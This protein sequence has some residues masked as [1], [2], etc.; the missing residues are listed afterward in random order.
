MTYLLPI[1]VYLAAAFVVTRI[2]YI[3]TYIS[4]CHTLLHEVFRVLISRGKRKKIKLLKNEFD[5][6]TAEHITLRH[7]FINYIS[8]TAVIL[9]IIG[10][11]YLVSTAN[12]KLI[13]YLLILLIAVS[14]VLWIRHFLEIIWALSF[15]V[16]LGLPLYSGNGMMISQTAIF[17]TFY[18]LLKSILTALQVCRQSFFDRKG[19]GIIG[20]V[21]WIPSMMLGL[22]LLVQSLYA[23]FFIV[24]NF[25][26]HIHI[27]LPWAELEF[28]KLPSV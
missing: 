18:L 2:P 27:G 21:K 5:L 22:A 14:I 24:S 10:F 6:E 23:G 17:L 4:L 9:V 15:A 16:L 11:C 25:V 28:V 13:L 19:K 1:I 26:F 12:Y 20:K 8:Y 7:H 3:R